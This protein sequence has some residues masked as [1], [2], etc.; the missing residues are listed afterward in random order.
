MREKKEIALLCSDSSRGNFEHAFE[1]ALKQRGIKWNVQ[2][3]TN[4]L[5]WI[6][7][8]LYFFIKNWVHEEICYS[9]ANA[10][11][12]T[13]LWVVGGWKEYV[14][15]FRCDY[16]EGGDKMTEEEFEKWWT[17]TQQEDFAK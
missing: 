12:E 5:N 11:H 6:Q 3:C 10:V 2:P 7:R 16:G 8:I 14:R 9:S 17:E 4:Q 13:M 1:F 15:Y